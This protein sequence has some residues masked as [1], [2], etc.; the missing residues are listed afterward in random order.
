MTTP[1]TAGTLDPCALCGNP[2]FV[3]Q[4]LADEPARRWLVACSNTTRCPNEVYAATKLTAMIEWNRKQR[5][6]RNGQVQDSVL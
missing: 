2:A 5:E 6:N 3:S 4:D 1:A